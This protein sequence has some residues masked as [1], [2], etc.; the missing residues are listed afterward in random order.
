MLAEPITLERLRSLLADI[1]SDRLMGLQETAEYLKVQPDE[2]QGWA[3]EDLIPH[4][5][6]AA[7]LIFRLREIVRW[8]VDGRLQLR[9]SEGAGQ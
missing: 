6:V 9:A 3:D 8:E 7:Q 1:Q 2:L 4:E 5:H